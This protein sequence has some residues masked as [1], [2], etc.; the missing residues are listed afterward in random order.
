ML[1]AAEISKFELSCMKPYER[2][3]HL[4]AKYT[5][6]LSKSFNFFWQTDE[7]KIC[8]KI[9]FYHFLSHLHVKI[10]VMC[11]TLEQEVW[12]IPRRE[13]NFSPVSWTWFKMRHSRL[14]IFFY[15]IFQIL[16][17]APIAQIEIKNTKKPTYMI[18]KI[19]FGFF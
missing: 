3:I 16:L 17:K 15:S 11:G 19:K 10:I 7:P 14:N 8:C 9:K 1:C 5:T 4:W 6:S 12:I 18:Q 2:C 13:Y